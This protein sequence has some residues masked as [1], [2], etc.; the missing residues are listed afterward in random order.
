MK[1]IAKLLTVI[2]MIV[3]L[4]RIAESRRACVCLVRSA[5]AAIASCR[6]ARPRN[7]H[8]DLGRQLR[9]AFSP[10]STVTFIV[11]AVPSRL[12]VGFNLRSPFERKLPRD[13]PSK[14]A[15]NFQLSWEDPGEHAYDRSPSKTFG[16]QREFAVCYQRE[17]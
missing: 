4:K 13:L 8:P 17:V 16:L 11:H 2:G 6:S 14:H 12:I 3:A 5:F 10:R 7:V 1:D 9:P 15:S